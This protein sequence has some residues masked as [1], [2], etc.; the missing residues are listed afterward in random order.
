MRRF[1]IVFPRQGKLLSF[2]KA[3]FIFMV[4]DPLIL[5]Y[6]RILKVLQGIISIQYGIFISIPLSVFLYLPVP[7]C[8]YFR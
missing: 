1:Y 7:V 4:N 6:F 2:L 3:T 8:L 5:H